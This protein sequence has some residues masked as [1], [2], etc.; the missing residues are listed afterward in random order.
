MYLGTTTSVGVAE[1]YRTAAAFAKQGGFD[2]LEIHSAN[3]YLL[4]QFLQSCSNK[5]NKKGLEIIWCVRNRMP[6]YLPFLCSTTH[7]HSVQM[8][9]VGARRIAIAYWE[10]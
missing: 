8:H 3:G 4:D 6:F 9:T 1:Q 5:V 7:I 10:K 2:G